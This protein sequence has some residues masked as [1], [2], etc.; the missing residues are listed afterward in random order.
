M[1]VLVMGTAVFAQKKDTVQI[2][3]DSTLLFSIRDLTPIYEEMK[4]LPYGSA[5]PFI[6]YLEQLV[7]TKVNEYKIKKKP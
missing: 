6:K 3:N 2:P 5:E 7:A 4:K 1:L